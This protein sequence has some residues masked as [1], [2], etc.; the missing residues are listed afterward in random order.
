M[1]IQLMS[2]VSVRACGKSAVPQQRRRA[3]RSASAAK[4]HSSPAKT[5]LWDGPNL[6]LDWEALPVRVY[7][8]VWFEQPVLL[9]KQHP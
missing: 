1:L 8:L 6:L 4:L 2:T 5:M 7:G 3:A 9:C